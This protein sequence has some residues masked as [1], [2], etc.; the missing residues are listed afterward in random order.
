MNRFIVLLTSA[1]IFLAWMYAYNERRQDIRERAERER[2]PLSQAAIV[3]MGGHI[4]PAKQTIDP[5]NDPLKITPPRQEKPT[6][7][8]SPTV[9]PD[10]HPEKTADNFN[11]NM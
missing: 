4:G 3:K 9:T 6:P 10:H 5:E 8:P 1:A 2:M 11:L 7:E